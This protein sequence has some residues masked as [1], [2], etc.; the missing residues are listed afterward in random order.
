MNKGA[1]LKENVYGERG[2]IER[3]LDTLSRSEDLDP[4]AR[5]TLQAFDSKIA[6]DGLSVHRRLFYLTW[7]PKIAKR[8]GSAFANPTRKDIEAVLRS[9]ES[10]GY[11]EWTKVNVRTALKRF[12]KWHLGDDDEFPECVRGVRTRRSAAMRG[13]LPKD[14]LTPEEV[15][16]LIKACLNPRDKALVSIIADTGCRIGEILTLTVGRVEVNGH[17][18]AI[19]V[20]GKTGDRRVLAVGDS[21]V[22]VTTW[23][24]LHPRRDDPD[25]PLFLGLEGEAATRGMTYAA[26]R[27][28][29]LEA[30]DRAG[31]KKRVHPHLFRHAAATALAPHMTEAA[32]EGYMGW[33]PGSQMASVYV[34][35]SGRDV[36]EAYLR[37]KGIKS[38]EAPKEPDLPRRC[39]R[40]QAVNESGARFCRLCGLALDVQTAMKVERTVQREDAMLEA[41]LKD[42]EVRRVMIASLRR[43]R[44]K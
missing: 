26:A 32:L 33:V 22:H 43:N 24:S 30:K 15:K 36:D 35:L 23:L 38:A 11:E 9:F 2:R 41:V 8:L 29:I 42:P 4:K 19:T 1:K 5:E 39:P 34:R 14:L 27:K 12:Y 20:S 18:L 31:I 44:G 17:G 21:L 16:A 3:R 13:R 6:A 28:A 40:C 10:E 7:L 25:A 37:A